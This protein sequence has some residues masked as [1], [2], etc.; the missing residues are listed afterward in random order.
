MFK[1]N[2][3]HLSTRI[4]IAISMLVSVIFIV[5]SIYSIGK[6]DADRI[7]SLDLRAQLTIATQAISLAG[8]LWDY[9]KER[10]KGNLRGMLEDPDIISVQVIDDAGELFLNFNA[11]QSSEREQPVEVP[12]F[13]EVSRDIEYINDDKKARKVGT[14]KVRVSTTTIAEALKADILNS[15][16]S[17]ITILAVLIIGLALAIRAFTL[18]ITNMSALMRLR[19]EGD[20][21]TEVNVKYIE[22]N[23]EIG[24]IARSMEADQKKPAR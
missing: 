16:I 15:I 7:K 6:N 22:R 2:S 23:D 3:L 14:I 1:F 12:L 9:D 24:D 21:T 11:S 5:Q 4:I 18:P 10:A 17:G 8:P 13:I 19:S 20:Y